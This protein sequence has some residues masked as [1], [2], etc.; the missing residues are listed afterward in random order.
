MGSGHAEIKGLGPEMGRLRVGASSG[1]S[2][3]H[4]VFYHLGKKSASERWMIRA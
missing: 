1:L 4:K 2:A 3:L